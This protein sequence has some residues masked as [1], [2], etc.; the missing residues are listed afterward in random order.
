MRLDQNARADKLLSHGDDVGLFGQT[1][2]PDA[3]AR[4]AQ[5]GDGRKLRATVLAHEPQADPSLVVQCQRRLRHQMGLNPR[6]GNGDFYRLPVADGEIGIGHLD[7]NAEGARGRI[8]GARE[9]GDIALHRFPRNQP[10]TSERAKFDLVHIGLGG[11]AHQFDR[12]E[13]DHH[14]AGRT[15]CQIGAKLRRVAFEKPSKRC[16]DR[17]VF[18]V[19]LD[20]SHSSAGAFDTG[21]CRENLGFRGIA[22]CGQFTGIGQCNFGFGERGMGLCKARIPCAAIKGAKLLACADGRA[23]AQRFVDHAPVGLCGH[24]NRACRFGLAAQNHS[25]VECPRYGMAGH[26]SHGTGVLRGFLRWRGKVLLALGACLRLIL[27]GQAVTFKDEQIQA[28]RDEQGDKNGDD[29]HGFT[30]L[31]L[32]LG[33]LRPGA[34]SGSSFLPEKELMALTLRPRWGILM[35]IT[36][37]CRQFFHFGTCFCI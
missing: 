27:S 7:F 3:L 11:I 37:S 18:N 2:D 33:V 4:V 32:V 10:C 28:D 6:R 20:L 29:A 23:L 16:G 21:L 25:R 30:V 19:A 24:L 34:G 12:V 5:D 14:S 8:G 15:G 26:H 35:A 13:L 9:E 31:C 1:G 22:P 36:R 17:E